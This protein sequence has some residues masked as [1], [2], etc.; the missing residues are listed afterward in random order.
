VS[1]NFGCGVNSNLAAMIALIE[2]GTISGKIAKELLPAMFDT[3]KAPKTLV[4][5]KG[6]VQISDTDAIEKAV[7]SVVA[8]HP[9]PVADYRAGKKQ[10]MGFLVGQVM[11]ATQGKANPKL[12]NEILM[13]EL[14]NG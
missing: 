14:N 6:L 1:A 5:E 3:G 9:G 10:A 2:Q 11:K 8:A 7:H 12:V 4:E 13:R